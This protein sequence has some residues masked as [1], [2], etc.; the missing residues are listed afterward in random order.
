MD[1]NVEPIAELVL[2][3]FTTKFTSKATGHGPTKPFLNYGALDVTKFWKVS[4]LLIDQ[5]YS[6]VVQHV[7]IEAY[8]REKDPKLWK[9]TWPR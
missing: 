5:P 3:N 7:S 2:P 4:T 8:S 9:M 1:V 6:G